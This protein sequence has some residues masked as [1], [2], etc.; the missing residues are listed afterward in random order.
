MY[1][2]VNFIISFGALQ[3]L[4]IGVFLL[5]KGLKLKQ[6]VIYLALI[7]M[8]FAALLVRVVIIGIFENQSWF[9]NSLNFILL[10][11]PAFYFYA[12]ESSRVTKHPLKFKYLHFLP[13]LIINLGYII[14]YFSLK[15]SIYYKTYLVNIVKVN[16]GFSIIYFSIYLYLTYKIVR[17]N[18]SLYNK[19]RYKLLNNLIYIFFGFFIIWLSYILAEFV[20][21][22]LSYGAHVL[23]SNDANISSDSLLY[24]FAS[25]Y[26]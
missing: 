4:I 22:F 5:I 12:K 11:A 2:I 21:F 14:F 25:Y 20:F 6:E 18:K 7:L 9:S 24:E 8:G 23:L 3:G 26:K 10:I 1:N 17:Q 19:T 13:F 16:D 15:G